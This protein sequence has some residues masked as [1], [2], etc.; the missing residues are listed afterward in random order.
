MKK[1]H[2]EIFIVPEGYEWEQIFPTVLTTE[3]SR[4]LEN[5]N[6]DKEIVGNIHKYIIE[7]FSHVNNLLG[8]INDSNLSSEDKLILSY[9]YD[10]ARL[11]FICVENI[12]SREVIKNIDVQEK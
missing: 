3:L 11:L 5:S 4:R 1:D 10:W 7:N 9:A 8:A 6:I 2:K 12:F